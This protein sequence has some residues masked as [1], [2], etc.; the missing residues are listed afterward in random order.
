[1]AL[2]QKQMG[3]IARMVKDLK[4]SVE[5]LEIKVD[6]KESKEIK[7]ILETQKVID[8]VIVANSD[9]IKRIDKEIKQLTKVKTTKS[10]VE[11]SDKVETE[12][13]RCKHKATNEDQNV[14]KAVV[15]K[16]C[17]Y[18]NRG[19]C[20]FKSKC[21]YIHPKETCKLHLTNKRCDSNSCTER[22]PKNCKWFESRVGCKQAECEYI[23]DTIASAVNEV[24]NYPCVSCKDTW[25][26]RNCVVEYIINKK[27]T[28]F[29]LNCD[30]WIQ[31]KTKVFEHGWTLMDN[32]G[33]LRTGI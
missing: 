3:G 11:T 18:Y 19:Y 31:Y 4:D 26:D 9:A 10:E 8:E 16:R 29:C 15:R 2:L 27:R 5:T 30:D 28:F 1:M 21:R 24:N 20:K 32:D 7:E 33:F 17:R 23:H 22:H 25:E 12:S 14:D 6:A 13:T